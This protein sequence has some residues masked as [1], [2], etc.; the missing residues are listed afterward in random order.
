MDEVLRIR[1]KCYGSIRSVADPSQVLRIRPKCLYSFRHSHVCYFW[2]FF[3]YFLKFR[4]SFLGGSRGKNAKKQDRTWKIVENRSKSFSPPW[5]P[6]TGPWSSHQEKK[7]CFWLSEHFFIA[8]FPDAIH[9][10]RILQFFN[11][12]SLLSEHF[13]IASFPDA[14]LVPHFTF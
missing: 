10:H 11:Y 8:S 7:K 6:M 9:Q 12:F 5:A 13:F 3:F 1:P 14:I 2:N 4:I